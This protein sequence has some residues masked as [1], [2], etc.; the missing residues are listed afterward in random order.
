MR[1]VTVQIRQETKSFTS[2]QVAEALGISNSTLRRWIKARKISPPSGQN[3]RF[4]EENIE[5]TFKKLDYTPF[6]RLRGKAKK[7]WDET[8][9]AT[10]VLESGG[11]FVVS[12]LGTRGNR[13]WVRGMVKKNGIWAAQGLNN[14][15][16]MKEYIT[17]PVHQLILS[18]EIIDIWI[19]QV[20]K[21]RPK[22]KVVIY[23]N[24]AVDS[25]L[26]IYLMKMPDE[27]YLRK[28]DRYLGVRKCVIRE[29]SRGTE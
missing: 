22:G 13:R 23:W 25:I 28:Y 2:S 27:K 26:C 11:I 6:P 18:K 4:S 29:V 1:K 8:Q 10:L 21:L 5:D 9:R 19:E 15:E 20:R 14:H 3:Y 7:N 16:H 17:N 24:G 12:P